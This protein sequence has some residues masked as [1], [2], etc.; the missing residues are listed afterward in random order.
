LEWI[1]KR[2]GE[3]VDVA[4]VKAYFPNQ[5]VYADFVKDYQISKEMQQELEGYCFE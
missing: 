3:L 5:E 4:F 2:K 1:G